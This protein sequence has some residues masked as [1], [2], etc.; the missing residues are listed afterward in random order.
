VLSVLL[1]IFKREHLKAFLYFTPLDL[2]TYTTKNVN[3]IV[4]FGMTV[5]HWFISTVSCYIL[6]AFYRI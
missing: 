3:V 1:I 2:S 6:K 4:S 5:A